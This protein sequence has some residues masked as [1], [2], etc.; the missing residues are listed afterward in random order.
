MAEIITRVLP[1][2]LARP[3]SLC[4]SKLFGRIIC[5]GCSMK[6]SFGHEKE[7]N[8]DTIFEIFVNVNGKCIVQLKT[9]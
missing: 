3:R 8:F 2:G 9:L 7:L 5:C 1:Q 6:A 4:L